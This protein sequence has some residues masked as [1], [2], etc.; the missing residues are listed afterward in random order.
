MDQLVS[1]LLFHV[2]LAF[3]LGQMQEKLDNQD[4][5]LRK[6]AYV[7]TAVSHVPCSCGLPRIVLSLTLIGQLAVLIS[8]WLID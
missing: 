4:L 2:W 3:G 7:S 8:D 1:Q 5:L 6:V